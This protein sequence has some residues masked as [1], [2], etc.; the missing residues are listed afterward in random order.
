MQQLSRIAKHNGSSVHARAGSGAGIQCRKPQVEREGGVTIAG[1][2]GVVTSHTV[3][4][5]WYTIMTA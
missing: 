1:S 2:Q 3:L 4:V 5:Y